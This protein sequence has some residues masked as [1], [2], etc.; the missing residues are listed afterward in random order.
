MQELTVLVFSRDFPRARI[1]VLL[2]K[3]DFFSQVALLSRRPQFPFVRACVRVCVHTMGTSSG[4]F[5]CSVSVLLPLLKRE[6]ERGLFLL[7]RDSARSHTFYMPEIP[8]ESESDAEGLQILFLTPQF[9]PNFFLYVK[10]R[11]AELFSFLM[12]FVIMFSM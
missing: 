12:G 1:P 8:L 10:T 6:N 5:C 11:A 4:S 3:V 9:N 7:Q 2:K